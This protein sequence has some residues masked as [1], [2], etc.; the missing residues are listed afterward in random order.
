MENKACMINEKWKLRW[1]I[2]L[3]NV[4]LIA[5]FIWSVDNIAENNL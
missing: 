4:F 5:Y 1:Q 3:I 2:F